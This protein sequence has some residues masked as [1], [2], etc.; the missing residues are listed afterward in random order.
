MAAPE[1]IA[2]QI[3]YDRRIS[4][5][6]GPLVLLG[7]EGE[8]VEIH[9][10]QDDEAHF[11]L[12]AFAGSGAHPGRRRAQGPYHSLDQALGARR[13]IASALLRQGY[14]PAGEEL[15]IWA[16]AAQAEVRTLRER[17]RQS[18]ASYRF[19]PKDVYLDW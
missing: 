19:D 7:P 1:V 2:M 10:R 15:A 4:S 8:R 11:A 3:D 17:H 16:L 18:R 14:A 9:L 13:A 12:F 6:R 5:D